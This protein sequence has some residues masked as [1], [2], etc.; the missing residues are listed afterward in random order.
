MACMQFNCKRGARITFRGLCM[1][2]SPSD[3]PAWTAHHQICQR[4]LSPLGA[5]AIRHGLVDG[6]DFLIWQRGFGAAGSPNTGDA[7]GDDLAIWQVQYGTQLQLNTA[8]VSVPEPT[9]A[10]IGALAVLLLQLGH[11]TERLRV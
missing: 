11:R 2:K 5:N 3:P 10:V 4:S 1:S 6:R 7:N 9:A 8:N